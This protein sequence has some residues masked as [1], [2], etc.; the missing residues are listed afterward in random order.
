MAIALDNGV[1]VV[2]DFGNGMIKYPTDEFVLQTVRNFNSA[3][4]VKWI[5][6]F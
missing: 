5:K 1:T 2:N 6:I 4:L 3:I